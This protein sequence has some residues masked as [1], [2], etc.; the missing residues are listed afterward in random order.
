ME[1]EIKEK[2]V[3]FSQKYPPEQLTKGQIIVRAGDMPKGIHF[4]EKGFIRQYVLS[5]DGEEMTLNIFRPVA[6]FPIPYALDIYT[7]NYFFEAMEE[8]QVRIAP[9]E[10]TLLF[11]KN[12][13]DVL[14]DL[15][16]RVFVGLEGI[17]VRME[18]LMSG[19]AHHKLIAILILSAKR[20]GQESPNGIAID[21]KL[22]HKDLASQ[23]GLS[24]ETVSREMARLKEKGIVDYTS[25]SIL[26]KNLE[27]LERII[28]K[29]L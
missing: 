11:L 14:L 21:V 28:R 23:A 29:S 12:N 24:R 13:P 17:L 9:K 25:S 18:H 2:I 20:F 26:I 4:L 5:N 16:K 10:D 22:T 3:E 7:P 1:E 8:S 27:D 6:F 19:E 15:L